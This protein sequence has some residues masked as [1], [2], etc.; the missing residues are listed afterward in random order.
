[1]SEMSRDDF[2]AQMIK[3]L[4]VIEAGPG[5]DKI[6]E[7]DDPEQ[8]L[9]KMCYDFPDVSGKEMISLANS[10]IALIED[11][12]NKKK[13]VF[14]SMNSLKLPFKF[15]ENLIFM[16]GST[17]SSSSK[18]NTNGSDYNKEEKKKQ[19]D[20][21]DENEEEEPTKLSYTTEELSTLC[22]TIFL[23]LPYY[24]LQKT[25]QD[26]ENIFSEHDLDNNDDNDDNG[27][28]D[29]DVGSD[30]NRWQ[31]VAKRGMR[32]LHLIDISL[33]SSL[34]VN[35]LY[36]LEKKSNNNNNCNKSQLLQLHLYHTLRSISLLSFSE[37]LHALQKQKNTI[38][39]FTSGMSLSMALCCMPSIRPFSLPHMPQHSHSVSLK[40]SD[41]GSGGVE[42]V[43]ASAD[44]RTRLVLL[45]AE[46]LVLV[47]PVVVPSSIAP[48]S[49]DCTSPSLRP[50][51]VGIWLPR[52][53]VAMNDGNINTSG[54]F[55]SVSSKSGSNVV[56]NVTNNITEDDLLFLHILCGICDEAVPSLHHQKTD[57]LEGLYMQRRNQNLWFWLSHPLESNNNIGS[58]WLY[59]TIMSSLPTLIT[60]M[61]M[62]DEQRQQQERPST[63]RLSLAQGITSSSVRKGLSTTQTVRDLCAVVRSVV[64]LASKE[65]SGQLWEALLHS[66]VFVL[67]ISTMTNAYN[68]HIS[69]GTSDVIFKGVIE[70]IILI[71]LKVEAASN[72]L[73]RYPIFTTF[74]Q[75]LHDQHCSTAVTT[76]ATSGTN[77]NNTIV[78]AHDERRDE[79]VNA[80]MH[81]GMNALALM[82]AIE[83]NYST[84]T[85]TT[86]TTTSAILKQVIGLRVTLS[87][88]AAQTLYNAIDMEVGNQHDGKNA[89]AP[90]NINTEIVNNDSDKEDGDAG[91]GERRKLA[92]V[93]ANIQSQIVQLQHCMACLCLCPELVMKTSTSISSSISTSSSFMSAFLLP[94]MQV[95]STANIDPSVTSRGTGIGATMSRLRH[96]MKRLM[97]LMHGQGNSSKTD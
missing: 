56:S 77:T 6:R 28:V 50:S 3:E 12:R 39:N 36:E 16:S 92:R 60:L 97:G 26:L 38:N 45:T 89:K 35:N 47:G 96:M 13:S 82:V 2:I 14:Q 72:F 41:M 15:F 5:L 70:I 79:E 51:F 7:L 21:D 17:I 65:D 9:N 46:V 71:T 86:T 24:I 29:V 22:A 69:S 54:I 8:I 95:I 58:K 78:T 67:L 20:D 55:N 53:L 30:E 19:K 25:L 23:S 64:L 63:P 94:L 91:A 42:G 62:I 33:L 74:V 37:K 88:V 93:R 80:K 81:M 40:L 76:N 1:M 34:G 31:K 90:T 43:S 66:Q 32:Y 68:T 57:H 73:L 75:Q 84:T 18:N 27:N 11:S 4:S 44:V 85:A 87:E 52:L 59:N 10:I 61:T 83:A 48:Y 49:D